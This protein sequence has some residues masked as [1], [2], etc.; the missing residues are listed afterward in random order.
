M[1]TPFLGHAQTTYNALSL[2]LSPEFPE[3]NQEFTVKLNDSGASRASIQ[4]F[5]DGVEKT[6]TANKNAIALTAEDIDS[7]TDISARVTRINGS[8]EKVNHIVT[9]NRVDLI[10]SSNTLVPN[11][12]LGRKLPSSGSTVTATALTFTKDALSSKSYSY[13]WKLNGK[14]QNG[15]SLF[16][17]N[18]FSFTPAFESQSLLT[19]EVLNKNGQTIARKSQRIPIVTPELYFYEQNPLRGLSFTALTNPYLFIADEVQIR[20]EGY[21]MSRDLLTENVLTEWKING[22]TSAS[23]EDTPN[24]ITLHKEGNVGESKLSFQIRNLKQLLQGAKKEI[25]I[26]F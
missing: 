24:E 15:G 9:P 12:Y 26:Q 2:E 14:I 21:F 1:A 18:T 5:I 10:I 13:V 17:E 11:F 8:V 6:Q 16:G 20:A 23:S 19:V 4:W 3:A 25:T 7:P 22:R